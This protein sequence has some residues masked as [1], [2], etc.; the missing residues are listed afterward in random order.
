[1]DNI[2]AWISLISGIYFIISTFIL[3]TKNFQ[4]ALFFK[5]IPF[6]LGV[7]C[8]F[9]AIKLFDIIMIK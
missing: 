9:V 2:C 7:G 5:I 8:I 3:N 6:F 4:S 1:M